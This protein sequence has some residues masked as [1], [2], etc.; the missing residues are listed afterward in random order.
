MLHL[1][2]KNQS[3]HIINTTPKQE[4]EPPQKQTE[5][6]P[7]VC[8]EDDDTLSLISS[9]EINAVMFDENYFLISKSDLKPIINDEIPTIQKPVKKYK[10]KIKS[11]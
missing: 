11:S 8:L 1:L 6:E 4:E 5:Y 10:P 3:R 7:T 2:K 9:N